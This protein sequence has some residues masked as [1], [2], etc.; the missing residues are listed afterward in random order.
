MFIFLPLYGVLEGDFIRAVSLIEYLQA[1]GFGMLDSAT[2]IGVSYY[3]VIMVMALAGVIEV[4]LVSIGRL[5]GG[6]RLVYGILG[7][8]VLAV[9]LFAASRQPYATVLLFLFF[10]VKVLLVFMAHRT[11][12]P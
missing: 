10:V 2:V 7:F 1:Y 12:K 11:R 8:Q 5:R 3:S 6:S 9:M 4:V